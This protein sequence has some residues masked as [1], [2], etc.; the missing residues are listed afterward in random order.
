[1]KFVYLY[2]LRRKKNK[3]V[4]APSSNVWNIAERKIPFISRTIKRIPWD[5]F[6]VLPNVH[7]FTHYYFAAYKILRVKTD[8]P[9]GLLIW[10]WKQMYALGRL[11]L[12]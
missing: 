2:M 9:S 3:K 6:Q 7:Q 8:H 12:R 5:M 11:L 1:M 4:K 10:D